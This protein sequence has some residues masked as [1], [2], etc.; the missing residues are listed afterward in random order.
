MMSVVVLSSNDIFILPIFVKMCATVL[1]CGPT[2]RHKD[3]MTVG[4]DG[5]H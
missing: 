4:R 1:T 5:Q 2:Q 3:V